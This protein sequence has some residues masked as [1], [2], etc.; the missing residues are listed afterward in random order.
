MPLVCFASPKGGV[1]KTL[2]SANVAAELCRLGARVIALDTD[3]QDTLGLHFGLGLFEAHGYISALRYGSDPRAWRSFVWNTACGVG[4][5]PHG[6]VSMDATLQQATEMASHPEI[7]AAPLRDML[8]D[9]TV[10]VVA[11]LPPGTSSALASLTPITDLL[12]TVLLVDAM[13][14]AQIPLVES[15]RFYGASTANALASDKLAYVLNQFDPRTRLGRAC[16]EA[17]VRHFQHRLLGVI[18]RDENVPEAVAAQQLVSDYVPHSKAAHDIGALTRAI[19]GRLAP[20]RTAAAAL[21]GGREV[22]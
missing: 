19:A 15:G 6:R 11:D 17:A 10:I 9:P 8:A 5:L 13:S 21:F 7:L 12:V 20:S 14:L 4:L 1:G 22:A 16:H 2:L 3:P 18:Y